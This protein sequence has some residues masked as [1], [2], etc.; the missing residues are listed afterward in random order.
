MRT[1]LFIL[2]LSVSLF[3]RVIIT[4]IMFNPSGNE[5]NDEFIEIYNDSDTSVD[6]NGW[7]IG[8]QD[9]AD[10]LKKYSGFSGM[11]LEPYS[12]C[13]VMDSSY[14]LNSVYY[15][16][17]IP[18]SVLRVMI[19]DGSFGS[20]GLSNTIEETVTL[21]DAASIVSDSHKYSIDQDEDISDERISFNTD[22]WANSKTFRGTPGFKNSVCPLENDLELI[23]QSV[24]YPP[25]PSNPNNFILKVK[26]AGSEPAHG[27]T[28]EA[29]A[30]SVNSGSAE[31]TGEL[32][33]GDSVSV[34]IM[35]I[36]PSSGTVDI[37]FTLQTEYDDDI[38]DNA[39]EI[40]LFVPYPEPPLVL[41]EFMSIPSSSQC[42]YIEIF[43]SSDTPVNLS[44]FG[45]SDEEKSRVKFFPDVTAAPGSYFVMAKNDSIYNFTGTVTEN[46]YI[47]SGLATLNNADDTIYLLTSEGTAIDSVAYSGFEMNGVSVEKKAPEL[48]S[49][50]LNSWTQCL[51]AGTPTKK[52]SVMPLDN[53]LKLSISTV[54]LRIDQTDFNT[55]GLTVHNAG[56]NTLTGFQISV[57]IENNFHSS[58][59]YP[60]SLS[61]GDSVNVEADVFFDIS[62]TV[63]LRFEL[64][65]DSDDDLTDNTA[66]T[67]VFVPYDRPPL[68]LN[69]FMKN[70]SAEQ[71]E[72]IEIVNVSD[73][74]IRLGDFGLSDENK[75][76]VVFFPDSISKQGDFIVMAKDS[77][78]FNF[79]GVLNSNVFTAPALASLNNT[80]D[81]IF[82]ISKDG[83]AIDSV[84]YSVLDDDAGR[85]IEKI[86]PSLPSHDIKSWVYCVN[87]GT[88]TAKNSVF[89]EPE[90]IGNS[91]NFVI[92]PKTATPNGDGHN[93]NLM[94]TY[95]FDSAYVYLTMK[96]YNIKG[97]IIASPLNGDYSSSKGSCVWNCSD[98]SGRTVDTGAYICLLKAKDDN[99]KVTELKEAFYIAK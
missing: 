8:D 30:D 29:Y 95:E 19:N 2:I 26:N 16:D 96:I 50:D 56:Y 86:N 41:N 94:V 59:D 6:L 39:A 31:Y 71:C 14:Y 98:S 53:D 45:I 40:S 54:P 11:I 48:D 27:F 52:N 42:E 68:V 37:K 87:T 43:V 35:V 25:D 28:I 88:P 76:N 83:L 65:T 81:S 5:N 15:E 18:D 49:D 63:E 23:I 84:S 78:I 36:F 80:S 74:E 12:Y 97:Q 73:G 85:S 92:S 20:Y 57:Y 55:F 61:P 10:L 89:Q 3:S 47:E 72:Y 32:I 17:L 58:A 66:P 1:P 33:Q 90:D 79:S 4:E 82:L 21:L 9:E 64:E 46:V 38:T 13:V 7:A 70:P 69:E 93:D 99:G 62:G 67:Q 75:E 22:E 24:P 91:A 77:L 60:H 51:Y 44:D 34:E